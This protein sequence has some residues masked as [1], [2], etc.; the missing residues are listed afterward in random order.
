LEVV[1]ITMLSQ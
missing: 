1:D